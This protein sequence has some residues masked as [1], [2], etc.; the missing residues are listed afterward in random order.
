MELLNSAWQ[1]RKNAPSIHSH[2]WISVIFPPGPMAP[3]FISPSRVQEPVR[4]SS[5]FSSGPGLGISCASAAT[6]T[7]VHT[8][9]VIPAFFIT[10]S[11]RINFFSLLSSNTRQKT[12]EDNKPGQSML[13][14]GPVY[15]R[16]NAPLIGRALRYFVIT[17]QAIRSPELPE[18]SVL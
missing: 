3:G 4:T 13:I 2:F 14:L 15:E 17:P 9:K 8:A 12:T 6:A 1:T 7:I 16:V 5:F 18:G 11:P 10:A